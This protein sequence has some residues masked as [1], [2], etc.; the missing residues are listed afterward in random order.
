M[1]TDKL[2]PTP[3]VLKFKMQ[4]AAQAQLAM[5]EAQPQQQQA[6][7]QTLDAAGNPAGGMNTVQPHTQG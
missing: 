6:A 4:K 2:V 5:A 3:E 7:P 1:D